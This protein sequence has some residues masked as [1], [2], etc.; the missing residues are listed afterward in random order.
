MRSSQSRSGSATAGARGLALPARGRHPLTAFAGVL[1]TYVLVSNEA[2][3]L[4][5]V[6]FASFTVATARNRRTVGFAAGVAALLVIAS[7]D[8]Q[9]DSRNCSLLL[10][11]VPVESQISDRAR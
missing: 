8:F 2:T 6:L 4:L 11:I 3:T 10:D 5:P 1:V 9:Y 7:T